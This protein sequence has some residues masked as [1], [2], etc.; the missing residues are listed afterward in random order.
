MPNLV[1]VELA[2]YVFVE[3]TELW[4]CSII[5]SA[6]IMQPNIFS[7]IYIALCIAALSNA[8]ALSEQILFQYNTLPYLENV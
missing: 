4:E 3:S 5:T 2:M 8:G 1:T 7:Q 6:H